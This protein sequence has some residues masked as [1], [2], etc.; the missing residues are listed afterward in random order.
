MVTYC[1]GFEFELF[2]FEEAGDEFGD[3]FG[4]WWASWETVFDFGKVAER[5]EFRK[6][7]GYDFVRNHTFGV[8]GAFR[9]DVDFLQDFLCGVE[10][11]EARNATI[12][13]AST[14]GDQNGAAFTHF[15]K[16]FDLFFVTDGA[17]DK[18]NGNTLGR[19]TMVHQYLN[20]FEFY[21]VQYTR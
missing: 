10:V 4:W 14:K 5:M 18:A 13:S 8:Y 9:V 16:E 20:I 12:G 15:M 6:V 17:R 21:C 19:F 1:F 7:G 3:E 2:A 11:G